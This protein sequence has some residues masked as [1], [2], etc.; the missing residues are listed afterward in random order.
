M[1][2]I[3]DAIVSTLEPY[4]LSDNAIRLMALNHGLDSES[5]YIKDEHEEELAKIE[6]EGLYKVITLTKDSD[7]GTSQSYNIKGIEE[8][9]MHIRRKW[10]FVDDT[11]P[12]NEDITDWW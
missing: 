5:E 12:V 3:Y 4:V 1:M 2:R 9:I 10:G 8:R 11:C 7:A 6:I